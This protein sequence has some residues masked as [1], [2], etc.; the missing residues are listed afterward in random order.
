[1]PKVRE[2]GSLYV[3]CIYIFV[4]ASKEFL[5]AH[6]PIK[7]KWFINKSMTIINGIL[8]G[9]ITPDQSGPGSN[10]NEGVLHTPQI[11]RT[12]TLPTNAV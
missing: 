10:G 5:F 12:G 1:M 9:T 11:P 2:L 7:Y 8:T 3:F 4:V 6:S